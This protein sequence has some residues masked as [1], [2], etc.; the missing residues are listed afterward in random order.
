MSE[1][2]SPK[3]DPIIVPGQ[4]S[5]HIA[6]IGPLVANSAALLYSQ[7]RPQARAWV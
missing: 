5:R 6:S 7:P 1:A 4:Q 2:E 3:D